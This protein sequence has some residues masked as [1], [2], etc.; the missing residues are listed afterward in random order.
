MIRYR[1][2]C[3]AGHEFESW[4]RSSSDYDR[5][6]EAGRITCTHCGSTDV[7]KA[8]MA[9]NV[10]A[11]SG[12]RLENGS[13]PPS[14]RETASGVPAPAERLLRAIRKVVEE[15]ADYVGHRFATEAR[16]IHT[17]EAPNR[18]IWGETSREEARALAE[19]GLPVT[20]LPFIP[21][22]KTN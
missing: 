12:T 10:A 5:L 9:P 18:P 21:S 1:L 14:A 8:L 16:A 11:R 15:N 22:R 7:E 17:G 3:R 4:F 19:E 6:S 2:R 13:E 20:P